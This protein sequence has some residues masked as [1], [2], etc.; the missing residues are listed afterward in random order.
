MRPVFRAHFVSSDMK[1]NF[2]DRFFPRDARFV[3]LHAVRNENDAAIVFRYLDYCY[4]SF[5][6]LRDAPLNSPNSVMKFG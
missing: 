1:A 4:T 3:A 6:S 5:D 2:G